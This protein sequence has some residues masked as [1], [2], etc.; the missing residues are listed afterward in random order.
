ML[1]CAPMRRLLALFLLCVLPLGWTSALA[2]SYCQH[3]QAP[4]AQAHFGH[5][6]AVKATGEDS[7]DK[8]NGKTETNCPTCHFFCLKVVVHL[9]AA[10]LVLQDAPQYML[11]REAIPD[12]SPDRLFRPP[13]T[14][15]L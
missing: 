14:A 10:P 5:H 4:E 13:L 8:S 1:N 2:A 11:A 7:T 15:G 6:D 12:H 3:E 9:T